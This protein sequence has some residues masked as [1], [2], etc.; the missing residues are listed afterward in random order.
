VNCGKPG[1]KTI[2][3]RLNTGAQTNVSIVAGVIVGSLVESGVKILLTKMIFEND[4]T[5][6][7]FIALNPQE[8]E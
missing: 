7:E 6:R 5:A 2:P 4:D 1:E 3:V 8:N